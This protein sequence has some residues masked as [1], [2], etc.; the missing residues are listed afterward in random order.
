[1]E[2]GSR[3]LWVA[4]ILCNLWLAFVLFSMGLCVLVVLS[5]TCLFLLSGWSG[6]V[7]VGEDSGI[8]RQG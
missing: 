8:Y 3:S 4:W 1:M 2:G 5:L 6:D 7:C